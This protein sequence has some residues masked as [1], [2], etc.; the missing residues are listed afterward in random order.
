MSQSS[1]QPFGPIRDAYT[2]FQQHATET[3]EDIRAYLPDI[4]DVLRADS[5]L[6]TLDFGCGDGG[7]TA[8]LH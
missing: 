6:R 8:A 3:E 5:P 1:S 4:H 2:F 7:V